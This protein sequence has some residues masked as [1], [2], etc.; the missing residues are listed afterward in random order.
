MIDQPDFIATAIKMF[1][2][3]LLVLGILMG[4]FY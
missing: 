4:S 2:A 3:L 1:S